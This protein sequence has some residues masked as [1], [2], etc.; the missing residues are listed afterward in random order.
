[1]LAALSVDTSCCFGP[2][3]LELPQP[4]RLFRLQLQARVAL[5]LNLDA[6]AH[7]HFAKRDVEIVSAIGALQKEIVNHAATPEEKRA[8]EQAG[9][10]R[11]GVRAVLGRIDQA[12]KKG[13]AEAGVALA[14]DELVPA[15]ERYLGILADVVKLQQPLRDEAK[16]A[17]LAHGDRIAWLGWLSMALVLA[18][19]VA[20]AL[21][22]ATA[23]RKGGRCAAIAATRSAASC[24]PWPRCRSGCTVS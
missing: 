12:R 23:G 15:V 6:S 3:F 2:A 17:A 7:E 24:R 8:L 14:L 11:K 5:A 9:E 10:A 1:V 16:A 18:L 22:R 20:G 19:G 21:D 4:R 13:R